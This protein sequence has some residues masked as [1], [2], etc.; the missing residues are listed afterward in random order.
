MTITLNRPNPLQE[1]EEGVKIGSMNVRKLHDMRN[2]VVNQSRVPDE[3]LVYIQKHYYVDDGC[4]FGLLD[5]FD[6]GNAILVTALKIAKPVTTEFVQQLISLLNETIDRSDREIKIAW[7]LKSFA[8]HFKE[9][10]W[11]IQATADNRCLATRSTRD[12]EE[13]TEAY[14]RHFKDEDRQ[15]ELTWCESL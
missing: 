3:F 13:L 1:V 12:S 11:T 14:M 8:E 5:W 4:E 9:T 7:P 15:G 2:D 6:D 10:G